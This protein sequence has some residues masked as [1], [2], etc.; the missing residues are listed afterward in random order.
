[1]H[2]NDTLDGLAF[3]YNVSVMAI[4]SANNLSSDDIF[5]YKQLKIPQ[6]KS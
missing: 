3:Q 2:P 1:M 6:G 4:K 5:F